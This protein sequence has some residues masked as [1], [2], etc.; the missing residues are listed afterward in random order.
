LKSRLRQEVCLGEHGGS[1]LD[2]NVEA[3]IL[4]G[5]LSATSVS[6]IRLLVSARFSL[7]RPTWLR[8]TFSRWM[9]APMRA[10]MSARFWM[11]VW[12][13]LNAEEAL[14]VV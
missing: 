11:A 3:G 2:D 10:R 5:F 13:L 12:M 9:F 1:A 4:G 7:S 6:R 14:V 8:V